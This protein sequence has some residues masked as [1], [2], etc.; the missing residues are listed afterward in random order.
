MKFAPA[1][2]TYEAPVEIRETLAPEVLGLDPATAKVEKPVEVEIMVTKDEENFLAQG[3]AVTKLSLLCGRC[4]NW[5]PWPIRAR[6]EH[7]FEAPHPN[8]IEL[9]PLVRE[10]ILLELPM[11]AVCR[12]G[13]DGRCPVTGEIYHAPESSGVLG[14]AEVWSELSKLEVKPEKKPRKPSGKRGAKSKE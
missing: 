10:D 12:L 3:W 2:V 4:T 9:T 7:L 13:A 11:N 5:M 6:I 1:L 8:S 14:N